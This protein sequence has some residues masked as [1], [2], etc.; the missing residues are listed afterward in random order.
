MQNLRFQPKKD[1]LQRFVGKVSTVPCIILSLESSGHD[2]EKEGYKITQQLQ[3][4]KISVSLNVAK[5]RTL[6]MAHK[7][8]TPEEKFKL[9]KILRKQ[10]DALP[11]VCWHTGRCA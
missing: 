1:D 5:N 8:A 11:T 10:R 7:R 6:E 2:E 3:E 9:K 4:G